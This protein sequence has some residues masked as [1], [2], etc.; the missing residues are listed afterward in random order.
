M[1]K[2]AWILEDARMARKLELFFDQP[3][4]HS[5][6]HNDLPFSIRL[7]PVQ[8]GTH[9]DKALSVLLASSWNQILKQ[10]RPHEQLWFSAMHLQPTCGHIEMRQAL[11]PSAQLASPLANGSTTGAGTNGHA[12][13]AL[14][15]GLASLHICC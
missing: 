9:F 11:S 14:A 10:T 7:L 4:K 1:P 8:P 5:T 13:C 12:S 2:T 6:S 15:C 3:V